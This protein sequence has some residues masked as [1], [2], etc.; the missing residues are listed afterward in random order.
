MAVVYRLLN[1]MIIKE[2]LAARQKGLMAPKMST[3]SCTLLRQDSCA[4]KFQKF[5]GNRYCDCLLFVHLV[6]E[7]E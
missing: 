6:S 2:K 4:K 7:A 1:I 3:M 5:S